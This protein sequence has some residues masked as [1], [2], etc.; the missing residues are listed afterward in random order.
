MLWPL[1]YVLVLA[2]TTSLAAV[3][4][5]C[6]IRL[7]VRWGFLD[8]PLSEAHK[9]HRQPI[10]V[11]GGLAMCLAWNATI[12]GG[13]LALPV[14][15][16]RLDSSVQSLLPGIHSV[17]LKLLIIAAGG[18]AMTAMGMRDDKRPMKAGPKFLLQFIV[19]GAVATQVH[20]SFL[21]AI[22]GANWAV[23][24]LWIMTV[25][26]ALNFFDNM[27]GLAGGTAMF[28][29]FFFLLIAA[30]R[31]QVFVALLSAAT[32]G[33]AAG[34]LTLNIPPAR[35]FM[36]D[37]GSH[38]LGYCL[39]LSGV[40]TT[41]YQT[42]ESLTGAPVLIPLLVLSLPLFDAVAVVLIRLHEH[43]PIYIGDNCHLSH[44][45]VRLG[46]SRPQ[47]VFVIWMLCLVQGFGAF[48]LIWLPLTGAILVFLQ[49]I[50]IFLVISIIQFDISEKQ[51]NDKHP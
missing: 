17:I 40:M 2:V 35:I 4:T 19:A 22:P 18:M 28:A 46:L 26:N 50:A 16:D 9:A 34:F 33:A 32:C 21:H 42:G 44:R 30:M 6:C 8:K 51:H 3:F 10:P 24:V 41:F 5:R 25:V 39:A 15:S 1:I 45:F 47:A 31:G 49:A 29:S 23:T 11:M 7:A 43:R 48:T 14:I 37:G 38:F 20:V 12:F 13:L 27:D 36:G